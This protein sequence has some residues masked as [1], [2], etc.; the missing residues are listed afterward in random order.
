[1]PLS[2][3]LSDV[4]MTFDCPHCKRPITRPGS[5]FKNASHLRCDHC[6]QSLRLTYPDK[7]ALFD[8]YVRLAGAK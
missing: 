3:A 4:L 5:Y 1:M 7:V 6:G 2:N 8:R